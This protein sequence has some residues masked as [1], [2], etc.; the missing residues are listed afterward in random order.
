MKI[1]NKNKTMW[2]ITGSDLS[3]KF[4]QRL[5]FESI[6]FEITSGHSLVL[7]GANGSGKTTLVRIICQ[8]NRPYRGRIRFSRDQKDIS[9][10]QIYAQ[11]GL[12][13]PYLQLYNHLTAFENYSF[14]ARIRGLA[15]D[16]GQLKRL[17]ER[18]GLRGREL[19]ELRTFSSGMLQRMKYVIALLHRP[20]F[21]IL[22]EP[23][24]NLDEAGAAL[25]YE[26]MQEQKKDRILIFATNEPAE[27]KFGEV[28]VALSA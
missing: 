24:A 17:M 12:V 23:T 28:K 11:L 25:V 4:N 20:E 2:Q 1:I 19:D 26:I 8:L 13:G 9:N 3:Q 21:L 5:I 22:D 27:V 6:S 15:V 16:N 18:M 7:T 10:Q 14:F